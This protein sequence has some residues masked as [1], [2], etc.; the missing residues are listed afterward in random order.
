[1]PMLPDDSETCVSGLGKAMKV[2]GIDLFQPNETCDLVYCYCG[3]RLHP[4]TC[5]EAFSVTPDGKF[6]ED[7]SVKALGRNCLSS[8]D[9]VDKFPGLGGC[10]KCLNTL[11]QVIT[12]P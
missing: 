10:S 2:R 6:V 3:I 9:N 1:M 5:P 8:S 11:Y 12:S 4:L 7:E